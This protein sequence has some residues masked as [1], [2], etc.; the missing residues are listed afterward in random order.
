[1]D[2]ISR[3]RIA[4]GL[5]VLT[6]VLLI[7]GCGGGGGYSAPPPGGNPGPGGGTPPP[8]TRKIVFSSNKDGH[9]GIYTIHPDGTGLTAVVP[10]SNGEDNEESALSPDGTRIAFRKTR[11]DNNGIVRDIYIANVDGS[12]IRQ[13]TNSG[14]VHVPV[15][16]FRPSWSPDGQKLAF[17]SG[18]DPAALDAN[19]YVVDLVQ[20]TATEIA[21]A[22]TSS[23]NPT[24][25]PD[26]AHLAFQRLNGSLA[27]GHLK[28]YEVN[29]DGS[30]LTP[31]SNA[32]DP[33]SDL[34]PAWSPQ[35]CSV[36]S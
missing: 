19:I 16:N 8:I 14:T 12:G 30:G 15:E 23:T 4:S 9:F 3:Y 36:K 11:S 25:S 32:G 6:G 21:H 20:G 5:A 22:A 34:R 13:V 26:G 10:S 18:N 1:M 28:L 7:S 29:A 33:S 27:T 24:W 35:N 17:A 2:S 31:L